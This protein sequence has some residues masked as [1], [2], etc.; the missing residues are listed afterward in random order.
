MS[1]LEQDPVVTIAA[2]RYSDEEKRQSADF[3][4]GHPPQNSSAAERQERLAAALAVDPGVEPWSWRAIQTLLIVLCACCCAFN[5][6]ISWNT[7]AAS[8]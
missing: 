6:S 8:D 3:I 2:T 5:I 4:E 7:E 1:T